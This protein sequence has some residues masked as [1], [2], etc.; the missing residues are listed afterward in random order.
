MG[1][2]GLSALLE[3]GGH[4]KSARAVEPQVWM[5]E[6]ED[7]LN[8]ASWRDGVEKQWCKFDL[9]PGLYTVS[10]GLD[11]KMYSD[12]YWYPNGVPLLFLSSHNTKKFAETDW[13]L[14]LLTLCRRHS[15]ASMNCP[16][17]ELEDELPQCLFGSPTER[18]LR[19]QP[20]QY[21]AKVCCCLAPRWSTPFFWQGT[22]YGTSRDVLKA[23]P[24]HGGK[25]FRCIMP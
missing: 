2:H 16:R 17:T 14:A 23:V 22:W 5:Q 11:Q 12:P 21:A 9:E 4:A 1:E 24:G 18:A 20:A 7:M 19:A 3:Q 8:V 25:T 13:L 10:Y 6:D 15:G